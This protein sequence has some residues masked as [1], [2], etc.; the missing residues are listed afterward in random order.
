MSAGTSNVMYHSAP[1]V[2]SSL[3]HTKSQHQC[4][5]KT[6]QGLWGRNLSHN[7]PCCA[8][9]FCVS[10]LV[11]VQCVTVSWVVPCVCDRCPIIVR[12]DWQS[13]LDPSCR[14]SWTSLHFRLKSLM[15]SPRGS[16][17]K[18]MPLALVV[19]LDCGGLHGSSWTRRPEILP[20]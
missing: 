17:I 14:Q 12:H 1:L 3:I 18:T 19:T 7:R 6:Q 9:S 13:Q 16:I 8:T 5:A 11:S 20:R 4:R 2:V 10:S 15:W